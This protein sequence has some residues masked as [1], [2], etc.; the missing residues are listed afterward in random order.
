M[1]KLSLFLS[2]GFLSVFTGIML[3]SAVNTK[4]QETPDPTIDPLEGELCAQ[5]DSNIYNNRSL[6]T[7]EIMVMY[8]EKTNEK[9][10]GY[11]R[12][13]ITAQTAAAEEKRVDENSIPPEPPDEPP[14]EGEDPMKDFCD[15]N[16][17]NYS[18]FCV[19]ANLISDTSRGDGYIQYAQA[20]ECRRDRIF[21]TSQEESAYN[22]YGEALIIGEENEQEFNQILQA[23]KALEISARQDAI[24]REI[25]TAKRALD[26][27]LSAYEELKTAWLMHKQYIK[28]YEQL[29]KYRDKLIEVRHQVEEY[30]A[31][32]I[33]ATTTMCT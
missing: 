7:E 10:N 21:E 4:A 25:R 30:P 5:G 23:Q 15:K 2:I 29:V 26:Q 16:R 17:Q 13:M 11:I 6:T 8:H 33:D 19:A 3:F 18:T 1:K 12:Q 24:Q 14:A 20:L 32:F 9:F 28:T 22:D 27:T 31:K